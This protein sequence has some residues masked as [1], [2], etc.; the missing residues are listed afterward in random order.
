[1]ALGE[2]YGACAVTLSPSPS[3]DLRLV[4]IGVPAERIARWDRGVDIER[5]GPGRRVAGRL[6]GEINVLYAGRLTREKGVDLLAESFL[7]ARAADPRLHLVLAGGGPE[8]CQLRERLG[9]HATFL[10]WLVGDGLAEAYASADIFLFASRTDTFG[11]VIL[12]AQ[13]SGTPVVAVAEGGPT[14]LITDGVTGLL[15]PASADALGAAVVELA[16]NPLLRGRLARGGLAAVQ[17]ATWEAALGRLADGYR[18]AL[19]EPV[20]QR[21]RVGVAA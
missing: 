10:G 20:D 2:F 6:P 5:F 12:E 19:G 13:A 3:S 16:G 14:G 7:A 4:E 8:E 18:L 9:E 21:R 15:R 11:Q 1:M 17:G